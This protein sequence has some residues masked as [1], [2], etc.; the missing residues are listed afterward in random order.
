MGRATAVADI[1][2]QMS[3]ELDHLRLVAPKIMMP[4]NDDHARVLVARIVAAFET[5]S[6]KDSAMKPIDWLQWKMTEEIANRDAEIFDLR[7]QLS[8][9]YQVNKP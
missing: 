8:E 9:A 6:F 3:D 7:K 4:L 2:F 5:C 1:A